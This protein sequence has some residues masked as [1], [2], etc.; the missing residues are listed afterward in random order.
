MNPCLPVPWGM[1][2]FQRH[3]GCSTPGTHPS[4]NN[5]GKRV[6]QTKSVCPGWEVPAEGG[7]LRDLQPRKCVPG[8][9]L[10]VLSCRKSQLVLRVDA[11]GP[12]KFWSGTLPDSRKW[13]PGRV[14]QFSR[15]TTCSMFS[16]GRLQD[17][18]FPASS[19]MTPGA[20]LAH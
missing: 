19:W 18:K 5:Y 4:N 12:S 16:G 14:C 20:A 11:T 7:L 9:I 10:G 17:R 8:K 6:L 13:S 1:L 2:V 15:T 3:Y